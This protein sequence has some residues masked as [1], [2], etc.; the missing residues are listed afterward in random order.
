MYSFF[1]YKT[2]IK[3]FSDGTYI[4]EEYY[5]E[6]TEYEVDEDGD[7]EFYSL[8][9]TI[10]L[11]ELYFNVIDRNNE[12]LAQY[13]DYRTAHEFYIANNDIADD[14]ILTGELYVKQ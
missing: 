12:I 3:K 8:N 13:S 5:V 11:T 7:K 6:E 14:I 1:F 2:V 9:D 4:L 10:G